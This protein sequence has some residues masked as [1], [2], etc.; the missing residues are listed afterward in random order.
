MLCR[1]FL[2]KGEHSEKSQSISAAKRS[3]SA[4]RRSGG[5]GEPAALVIH[6]K[7]VV[8]MVPVGWAEVIDQITQLDTCDAD[9]EV[10]KSDMKQ[11]LEHVCAEAMKRPTLSLT[12]LIK[13]ITE[14]AT[15]VYQFHTLQKSLK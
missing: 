8:A 1:L 11:V 13:K 9:P 7:Q 15:I 5:T 4:R 12:D 14:D 6:G 10:I 3:E 2:I